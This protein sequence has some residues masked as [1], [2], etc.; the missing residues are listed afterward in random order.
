M[1]QDGPADYGDGWG[2]MHGTTRI[3]VLDGKKL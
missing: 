1:N 2:L 3:E